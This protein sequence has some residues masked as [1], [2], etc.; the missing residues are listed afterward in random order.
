MREMKKT[1]FRRED[2][3]I[4]RMANINKLLKTVVHMYAATSLI[5]DWATKFQQLYE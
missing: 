1:V 5:Q 3:N 2:M 4:E